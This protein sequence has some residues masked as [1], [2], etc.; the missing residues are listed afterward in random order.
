MPVTTKKGATIVYI[1]SYKVNGEQFFQK[2]KL[3]E[4]LGISSPKTISDDLIAVG[5]EKPPW[6]WE[7]VRKLIGLKLFLAIK[8]GS[9]EYSRATYSALIELGKEQLNAI[10]EEQLKALNEEELKAI[11]ERPLNIIFHK[12]KIDIEQEFQKVK[13]EYENH[14]QRTSFSFRANRRRFDTAC[15]QQN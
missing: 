12:Y 5:E 9:H 3:R 2:K 14:Q 7:T 4:I 10:D 8:K 11:R 1:N 6:N 13:N 15:T